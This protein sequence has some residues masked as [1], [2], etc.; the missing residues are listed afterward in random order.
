MS[1]DLELTFPVGDNDRPAEAHGWQ[2]EP[3]APGSTF[4]PWVSVGTG[5]SSNS[6]GPQSAS[7]SDWRMNYFLTSAGV[8]RKQTD[9]TADLAREAMA[10]LTRTVIATTAGNWK[11]L[12]ARVASIGGINKMPQTN[13]NY[14][15]QT[16][17]VELWLSKELT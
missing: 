4:I 15:I 2:G 11:I 7:Q 3:D 10:N 12:Q 1:L 8:A 13:P 6:S 17:V 5:T 9:R 16:D 14:F